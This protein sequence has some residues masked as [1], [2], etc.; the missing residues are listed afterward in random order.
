METEIIKRLLSLINNPKKLKIKNININF[1]IEK[2]L[3]R[4]IFLFKENNK[5]KIENQDLIDKFFEE[6]NENIIN[7]F[8]NFLL[9]KKY[10][11][12]YWYSFFYNLVTFSGLAYNI[13]QHILNELSK[14]QK[15]FDKVEDF[16]GD[17]VLNY[18]LLKASKK[19]YRKM[20]IEDNKIY[21]CLFY[22]GFVD[23]KYHYE[24]NKEEVDKINKEEELEKLEMVQNFFS[25]VEKEEIKIND[26]KINDIEELSI[27]NKNIIHNNKKGCFGIKNL[28]P[29]LKEIIEK[30][31]KLDIKEIDKEVLEK[32]KFNNKLTKETKEEIKEE[33]IKNVNN[34]LIDNIIKFIRIEKKEQ[35]YKNE[36]FIKNIDYVYKIQKHKNILNNINNCIN[37][38]NKGN[39]N[40]YLRKNF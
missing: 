6:D 29:V 12:P 13:K 31:E 34:Y 37:N 30:Q 21:E 2:N 10:I 25:N 5:F 14:L 18:I 38:I 35:K 15:P 4:K 22:Y 32:V 19:D 33:I 27:K 39:K 23:N 20:I 17:I 1:L 40:E 3:I 28:V 7:E 9:E 8:Y 36:F 16:E 11:N 24:I 26:I